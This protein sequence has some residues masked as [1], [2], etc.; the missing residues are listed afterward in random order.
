MVE[1][2]KSNEPAAGERRL[3]YILAA[4]GVATAVSCVACVAFLPHTLPLTER[5][6][7]GALIG[8]LAVWGTVGVAAPLMQAAAAARDYRNKRAGREGEPAPDRGV[9]QPA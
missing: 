6:F 4:S 2:F 7:T 5:F 3:G 9:A 8:N 1:T